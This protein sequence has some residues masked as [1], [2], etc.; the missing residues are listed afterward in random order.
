MP[1]APPTPT[2]IWILTGIVTVLL[3][4]SLAMFRAVWGH[5]RAR[6]EEVLA[7]A[8]ARAAEIQRD[9]VE[10]TATAA[11][12]LNLAKKVEGDLRIAVRDVRNLSRAHATHEVGARQLAEG[13][14]DNRADIATMQGVVGVVQDRLGLT[15][16]PRKPE[17]RR[18]VQYPAPTALPGDDADDGNGTGG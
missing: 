12:A 9:L 16:L 6:P 3:G 2:V 13:I 8:Q 11:A 1:D 7:L 10:A 14:N 15:P 18:P 17:R 4:A 5:L